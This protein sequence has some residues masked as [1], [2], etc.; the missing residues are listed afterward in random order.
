[1]RVHSVDRENYAQLK[2]KLASL[3]PQDITSYNL[4]KDAFIAEIDKKAGFTGTRMV[5]TFTTREWEAARHFRQFIGC[6][7]KF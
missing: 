5:Q 2:Q 4:G 3:Y 1:M 6:W 7:C